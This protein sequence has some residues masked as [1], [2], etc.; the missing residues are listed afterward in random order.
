MLRDCFVEDNKI[1]LTYNYVVNLIIV[2]TSYL[3]FQKLLRPK[4]ELDIHWLLS[5]LFLLEVCQRS[6][7]IC[8]GCIYCLTDIF[9]YFKL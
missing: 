6:G 7:G 9:F 1:I 3:F 5:L 8:C 2:E 4:P